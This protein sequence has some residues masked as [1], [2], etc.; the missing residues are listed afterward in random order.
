MSQEWSK[1]EMH[2]EMRLEKQ[3]GTHAPRILGLDKPGFKKCSLIFFCSLPGSCWGAQRGGTSSGLKS[4]FTQDT[5]PWKFDGNKGRDEFVTWCSGSFRGWRERRSSLTKTVSATA[6]GGPGL[7]SGGAK[8]GVDAG[9]TLTTC[10]L[11]SLLPTCSLAS[12]VWKLQ[13]GA[14]LAHGENQKD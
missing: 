13:Q 1:Q 3:V 5:V 12:K 4:S 9:R 14:R 6:H 10:V 7:E 11:W 2:W 8:G